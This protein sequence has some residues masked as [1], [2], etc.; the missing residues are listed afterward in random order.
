[1]K[2]SVK[3]YAQVV[4]LTIVVVLIVFMLV[5]RV[6]AIDKYN[7]IFCTERCIVHETL[8]IPGVSSDDVFLVTQCHWLGKQ[9]VQL[10][11]PLTL[12]VSR[13]PLLYACDFVIIDII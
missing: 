2:L 12:Y 8:Y 13:L 11:V 10:E 7:A 1:M 5:T 9:T 3:L 4:A 6:I